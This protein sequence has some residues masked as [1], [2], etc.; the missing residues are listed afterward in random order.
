MAIQRTALDLHGVS[1]YP[2]IPQ[3][4]IPFEPKSILVIAEDAGCYISL[5]GV[6]D[7]A[8][9]IGGGADV[10]FAS[11]TRQVWLK[12]DASN[13]NPTTVQIIVEN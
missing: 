1:T 12:A 11:R 5:D 13:G 8:H 9:L 6:N 3:V 10:K 7:H 2:V 4:A